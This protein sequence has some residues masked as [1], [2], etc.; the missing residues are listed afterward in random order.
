MPIYVIF[1]VLGH[2]WVKWCLLGFHPALLA[3]EMMMNR[4]AQPH[5]ETCW[6]YLALRVYPPVPA[7]ATCSSQGRP[8]LSR[9]KLG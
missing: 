6:P 8:T 1:Y 5:L 4:P 2:I 7:S 9:E 3:V